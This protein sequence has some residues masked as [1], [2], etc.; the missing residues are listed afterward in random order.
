MLREQRDSRRGDQP[1][2]YIVPFCH[3]RPI[4]TLHYKVHGVA[5]EAQVVPET[6]G[7]SAARR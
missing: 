1:C 3:A 5:V 2:Q 4:F 6:S 7:I